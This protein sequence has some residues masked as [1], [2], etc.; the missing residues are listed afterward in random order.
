MR[1]VYNKDDDENEDDDEDE[2]DDIL[3]AATRLEEF[4]FL[5]I[6]PF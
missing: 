5:H 4:S 3:K 2:D 1:E 6:L